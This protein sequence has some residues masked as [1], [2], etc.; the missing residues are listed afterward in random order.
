MNTAHSNMHGQVIGRSQLLVISGGNGHHQVST[1]GYPF[2]F[3]EGDFFVCSHVVAFFFL[4]VSTVKYIA[5]K[6]CRASLH[7]PPSGFQCFSIAGEVEL[8]RFFLF[9]LF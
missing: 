3:S 7:H 1:Q 6:L 4:I 5:I 2:C 8:F 9:T